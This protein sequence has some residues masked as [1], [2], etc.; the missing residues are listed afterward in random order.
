MLQVYR[1]RRLGALRMRSGARARQ[2]ASAGTADIL[3]DSFKVWKQTL[4]GEEAVQF[5][6]CRK[7]AYWL[8]TGMELNGIKGHSATRLILPITMLPEVL[9][10]FN[11]LGQFH[12]KTKENT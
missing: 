5:K 1:N 11:N 3:C 8:D 12:W 7:T 10:L 6:F 2:R 4:F 9:H